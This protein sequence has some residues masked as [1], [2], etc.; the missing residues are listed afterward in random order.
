MI[1]WKIGPRICDL[2]RDFLVHSRGFCG[3]SRVSSFLVKNVAGRSKKKEKCRLPVCTRFTA[4][5]RA[6]LQRGRVHPASRWLSGHRPTAAPW[7]LAGS[8]WVQGEPVGG[9]LCL[10]LRAL[11][12]FL[13][14]LSPKSQLRC[15]YLLAVTPLGRNSRP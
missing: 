12:Q 1:S 3:F 6:A 14:L 13:R 10:A 11:R 9:S 2:L 8:A 4:P 7:G 15:G 5:E